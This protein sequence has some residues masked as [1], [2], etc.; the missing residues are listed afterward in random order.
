[1]LALLT[2]RERTLSEFTDLLSAS[3]FHLERVIPTNS[4]RTILEAYK[5]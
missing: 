4:P 5:A 3:G 1:M 2:G